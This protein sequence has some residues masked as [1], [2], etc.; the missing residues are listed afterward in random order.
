MPAATTT[1]LP[2]LQPKE[3]IAWCNETAWMATHGKPVR[4]FVSE[5]THKQLRPIFD[6]LKVERTERVPLTQMVELF[7]VSA[8]VRFCALVKA[9]E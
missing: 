7:S 2:E 3:L 6:T 1:F 8:L 9:P 5:E 4:S